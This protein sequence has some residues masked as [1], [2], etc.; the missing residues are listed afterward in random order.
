MKCMWPFPNSKAT[1]IVE[2]NS[3]AIQV[4]KERIEKDLA[5]RE[6]IENISLRRNDDDDY[7]VSLGLKV[8]AELS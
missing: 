6:Y 3:A 5:P 2:S 1:P 4:A 8:R 7:V